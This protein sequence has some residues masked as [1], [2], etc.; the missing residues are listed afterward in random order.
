MGSPPSV[1]HRLPPPLTV[2]DVKTVQA[3]GTVVTGAD[4]GEALEFISHRHRVI[5]V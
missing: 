5:I 2:K 1:E 3:P 4:D